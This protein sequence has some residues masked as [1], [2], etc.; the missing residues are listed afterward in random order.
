MPQIAK[1]PPAQS[2]FQTLS[3][4]EIA[5]TRKAAHLIYKAL[6]SFLLPLQGNRLHQRLLG[7][8]AEILKTDQYHSPGNRTVGTGDVCLLEGFDFIPRQSLRRLLPVGVTGYI[9]RAANTCTLRAP[10]FTP[11][12]AM[13]LGRRVTHVQL[14]AVTATLDF[15]RQRVKT[16]F[17]AT[18]ALPLDRP[19][20]LALR[21]TIPKGS[22]QTI[23][24]VLVI[25]PLCLVKA[26]EGLLSCAQPVVHVVKAE[27]ELYSEESGGQRRES[28][29]ALVRRLQ[30]TKRKPSKSRRKRKVEAPI[31]SLPSPNDSLPLK[32]VLK[33]T[34]LT[35]A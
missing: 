19:V 8:L 20:Q 31:V 6:S 29:S 9:D 21:P 11:G 15:A 34:H 14:I 2:L 16:H 28:G 35:S 22:R 27:G 7:R 1:T 12:E 26:K 33:R 4:R 3:E 18:E 30:P 17:Q 24:V 23:L 5:R 10:V 13:R 25:Q 32:T